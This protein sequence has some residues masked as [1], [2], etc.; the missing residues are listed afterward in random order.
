MAVKRWWK[1][2]C[3][4]KRVKAI[5]HSQA[6]RLA[7]QGTYVAEGFHA[8]EMRDVVV[9][10]LQEGGGLPPHTMSVSKEDTLMSELKLKFWAARLRTIPAHA[11]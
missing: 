2:D 9:I 5:L 4:R 3:P 7:E 6:L 8:V 10:S 1:C 11:T